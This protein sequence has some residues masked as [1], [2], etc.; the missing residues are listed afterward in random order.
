M[1]QQHGIIAFEMEGAG[2]WDEIP[3]IIVKSVCDYADSH[4]NKKWQ[5]FAAV[6]A[7]SATK[8][9]LNMY[10]FSTAP[11]PTTNVSHATETSSPACEQLNGVFKRFY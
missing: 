8:A 2:V 6:A 1:A 11:I 10:N 3:C 4:K 7:A 5:G 9:V